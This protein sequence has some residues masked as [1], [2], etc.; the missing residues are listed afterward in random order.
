[1]G[2]RFEFKVSNALPSNASLYFRSCMNF[3]PN[4]SASRNVLGFNSSPAPV[5]VNGVF[6]DDDEVDGFVNNTLVGRTIPNGVDVNATVS[7]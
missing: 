6:D 2:L 5:I 7:P 4:T 3:R 1:M